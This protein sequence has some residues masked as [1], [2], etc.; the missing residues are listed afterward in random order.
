MDPIKVYFTISEQ[1]YLRNVSGFIQRDAATT[2]KSPPLELL[3]ADGTVHPH[4]GSFFATDNQLDARTGALRLAALFPNPGHVLLPG[5][6]GR[7]R[8]TTVRTGAL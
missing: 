8:L 6:F 5:Q 1:E 7:V 2:N 4:K 3:L